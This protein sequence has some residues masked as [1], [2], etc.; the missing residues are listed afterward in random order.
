MAS[1]PCYAV[2][3]YTDGAYTYADID[4][5]YV[6]LYSYD[7]TSPELLVPETYLNRYVSSVYDYAFEGNESITGINF[8]NSS[9]LSTIGIKSF[10][11]CTN[12]AGTLA[13]PNSVRSIGLGA[14]EKCT[15][16][17]TVVVNSSVQSIPQQCFNRCESLNE[18]YLS[19]SVERIEK[20]AFANCD[21]LCN[22]YL[23][24]SVNY[25]SSTAF[26]NSNYVRFHVWYGSYAY[27]YAVENNYRYTLLDNVLLGD[28][29]GDDSVN[30]NDVT[31]V[32]RYLAELDTLEGINLHA[33]DT[34]QDGKVDIEDATTIQMYLAEY[35]MDYPIGDVMT[36]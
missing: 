33:A 11:S 2:T 18:V 24:T 29:N 35:E 3:L 36:Q 32:Q 25:I 5:D 17:Q 15:S 13:L 16:L 31:M 7:G 6:A 21:S 9:K 4:D 23:S 19:P 1:I 14:F 22:I 27:Q 20:L 28:A 34:N 30:I 26:M 8:S 12:L 10:A